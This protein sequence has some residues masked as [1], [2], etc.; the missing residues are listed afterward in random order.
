M[1][2]TNKNALSTMKCIIDDYLSGKY[3]REDTVDILL[4]SVDLDVIHCPNPEFMVTDCYYT[5]KHLTEAGH[6]TTD[7]ELVYFRD[8]I[9]GVRTYDLDEKMELT[10]KYFNGTITG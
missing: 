10:R 2:A 9:S 4:Y 8:C 5:I 1:N 3:N 6:E 7:F